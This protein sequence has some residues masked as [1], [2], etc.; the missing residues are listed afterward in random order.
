MVS[1]WGWVDAILAC[2][3]RETTYE[4]VATQF[5]V[6]VSDVQRWE[7]EFVAAGSDALNA[8]ETDARNGFTSPPVDIA[9]VDS[10]ARSFMSLRDPDEIYLVALE[11][12]QRFFGHAPTI[13]VLEN[14]ELVSKG[15]YT[16][17]GQRLLP[18][19]SRLP[20]NTEHRVM[21]AAARSK[22]TLN[23]S[24]I[25]PEARLAL[26]HEIGP[27]TAELAVPIF[28]KG[29]V[30]GVLAARS[31]MEGAFGAPDQAILEVVASH[32]AFRLE[33][34]QLARQMQHRLDQLGLV[35]S[36]ARKAVEDIDVQSVLNYTV[37]TTRERMGYSA[38]AVALVNADGTQLS[39]TAAY[40]NPAA[41]PALQV[42]SVS[43]D[44]HIIIGAALKHGKPMFVNNVSEHE[45]G[46]I[47]PLL[48]SSRSALS[49]PIRVNGVPI[50][51]FTVESEHAHAFDEAD[52]R[53]MGILSDQLTIVFRG[54]GL[55][56]QTQSQQ[57]EINLFRRL[58]DEAI[59]GIL[60]RDAEGQIDYANRAAAGL[61]GFPDAA[62]MR[63]VKMPDLYRDEM[64][65]DIDQELCAQVNYAGGW[66]GEIPYQRR[67]GRTLIA[68]VTLFPMHDSDGMFITYGTIIQDAT[69]RR[70]LL[71]TIQQTNSRLAAVLDATTDAVVVWDDTWRVLSVNPA[72]ERLLGI[73]SDQLIGSSRAEWMGT[74]HLAAIVNAPQGERLELRSDERHV[75]RCRNLRWYSERGW[76]HLTVIYDETSQVA[77]EEAREDMV[78]MIVHDL[79]SPLS[80]L[81]GGVEMARVVL[82]EDKDLA[83]AQHF[84]GLI[85]KGIVRVMDIANLLLDVNKFES[86]QMIPERDK[87]DVNT[88][89][90]DVVDQ[91]SSAAQLVGITLSTRHENDLPRLYADSNL[92][93][94]ADK[95]DRQRHQ[96]HA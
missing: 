14:A 32:L 66:V 48:S 52:A 76:G 25:S 1:Y 44:E 9:I 2:L 80:S 35:E 64:W 89:F 53:A 90:G 13:A 39:L 7:R 69:E 28:S 70:R 68:D 86:G 29:A 6:S 83:K 96:V 41:G 12:L 73:R 87:L 38:A 20:L 75:V 93:R 67:D 59:V 11:A 58:A 36:V 22:R 30:I 15:A 51:V 82:T 47:V 3:R 40:A 55:F 4:S 5:G 43:I 10:I 79:R 27:V 77:L 54:S 18:E 8:R 72:A 33:N 60:T 62:S 78:S 95:S 42:A 91:M 24:E 26:E 19:R 61:F 49:V 84:V 71:D 92:L 63:G 56:Q 45:G 21:V 16:L 34:A 94:R 23:E 50:G 88:I 81:V 74:P 57:R 17:S 46:V 65:R 31:G 85:R 37:E